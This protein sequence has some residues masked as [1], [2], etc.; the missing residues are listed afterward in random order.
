MT[1]SFQDLFRIDHRVELR[2]NVTNACNLHCDFC[3]HDAHIPFNKYSAKMFRQ[4]PLV[5]T[6]EA[7][8]Q[9]CKA[10]VGVG[11]DERH[12]LQGGEIT[13]LPVKL[14]VELIGIL[15]SYGRRVG[16]RSNGYNVCNI[17]LHSLN[18]LDF[19][20]LNAHG[21]NQQAIE[22]SRDFLTKNYDG[23]IIDEQNFYH[24]D[25]HAFAHHGQGSVEQG[26]NCNHMLATLTYLPPIVH[27]C[28]N[29][30]ALMNTLNDKG[31][32]ELLIKAGWTSDNPNL[33]ETLTHW[34]DTLPKPFLEKFCANSCYLTA[35]ESMAP[36]QR[37]QIHHLD[38][39]LKN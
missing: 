19:I 35:P 18:K 10:L 38:K 8:E 24:R 32:R 14:I 12:V 39:V 33:K 31:M 30:W 13:V 25:L 15:D 7:L 4:T 36:L 22:H 2:I 26:L 17:P 9:F 37:I 28:C 29:S 16:M 5:A 11:E 1:A 27:P 21:N 20:Y 3:D 23:K 6:P 34:R